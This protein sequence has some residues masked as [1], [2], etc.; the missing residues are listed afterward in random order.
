MIK[1]NDGSVVISLNPD[2][3]G[4]FYCYLCSKETIF[5]LLSNEEKNKFNILKLCTDNIGINIC[6]SCLKERQN[7]NHNM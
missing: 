4:R 2:M 5:I 3:Y 7:E 6:I 1:L